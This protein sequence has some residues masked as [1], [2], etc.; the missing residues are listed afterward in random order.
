MKPGD[1]VF[2]KAGL[3][4]CSGYVASITTVRNHKGETTMLNVLCDNAKYGF[5]RYSVDPSECVESYYE[6]EAIMNEIRK[7][8]KERFDP[9]PT[10]EEHVEDD[11]LTI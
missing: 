5:D 11:E 9:K 3:D 8:L 7:T 4:I 1:V 2:W 10:K 6:L